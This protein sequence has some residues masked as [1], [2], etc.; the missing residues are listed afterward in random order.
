MMSKTVRNLVFICGLT[1]ILL[2][3]IANAQTVTSSNELSSPVYDLSKE[4]KIQGTIE[5]IDTN[6]RGG[7]IGT[8]LL[9]MTPE[10]TVDVHL[11][12]STAVSA[13]NLGISVGESINL[14]GM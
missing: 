14:T 11:G 2:P 10:G 5:K 3:F 1:V 13:K 9:V 12:A 6:T 7:L 8:H 4:I